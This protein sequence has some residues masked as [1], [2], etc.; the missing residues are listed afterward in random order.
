MGK[1]QTN[2][3]YPNA[4]NMIAKTTNIVGDIVSESDIRIDGNIKGTIQTKGK[5]VVG[6]TGIVVGTI[7]CQNA[8]IEGSVEGKIHVKDL[9]S[10]KSTANIQ[11]EIFTGK[12][13]IEPNAIFTGTCKMGEYTTPQNEK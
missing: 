6:Q 13:A 2:E 12:L 11:G 5:I 4:I 10:L 7:H 8:E 1:N 9:L 3:F